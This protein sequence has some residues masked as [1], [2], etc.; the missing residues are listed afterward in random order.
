[1]ILGHAQHGKDTVGEIL[2]DEFGLTFFSS[3]RFAASN[4][5]RPYL[6]DRGIVYRNVEECYE[7]RANHRDLWF[8]AISEYNAEDPARLTKEMLKVSDVY[9]GLRCNR[10]FQAAKRLFDLVI[11]VDASKRLGLEST[12]SFDIDRANA[13][14]VIDNN[15]YDSTYTRLHSRLIRLMICMRFQPV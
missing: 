13:D 12:S 11:W 4:V 14:I 10:E 7:D 9:V 15:E 8:D 6:E 2:R 3:S 1:M 5:C